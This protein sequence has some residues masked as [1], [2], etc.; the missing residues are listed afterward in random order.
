MRKPPSCLARGKLSLVMAKVLYDQG[1][2]GPRALDAAVG[3]TEKVGKALLRSLVRAD[4]AK[5]GGGH[6]ALSA[7]GRAWMEIL[8]AGGVKVRVDKR[9]DPEVRLRDIMGRA[10]YEDVHW[11]PVPRWRAPH[12]EIR[13]LT[14]SAAG[15][16]A[17]ARNQ[18]TIES[19]RAR[20]EDQRRNDD[21]KVRLLHARGLNSTE[22]AQRLGIS[23]PSVSATRKRLGLVTTEGEGR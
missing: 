19:G 12:V 10:R 14:G 21:E 18:P 16:C 5:M 9:R 7:Y 2:V 15:M 1:M 17:E 23:R 3:V 20:P 4:V 22:I 8:L 6:V 13:S 11:K